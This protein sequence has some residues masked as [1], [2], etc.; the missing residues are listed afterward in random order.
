MVMPVKPAAATVSRTAMAKPPDRRWPSGAAYAGFIRFMLPILALLIVWELAVRGGWIA[1]NVFPSPSMIFARANALL[2][3]TGPEQGMLFQHIGASLYR[4][5]SAFALSVIIAIPM[6]FALGLM[7]A[8]Y[9]WVSPILS[10][11]LP[12]PAVAWT[13]ILLVAFGQGDRTI[14]TVCFL[15]AFF[16]VLYSTIQ[17]VRS[18]G[19]QPVWVVQSMGGTRRHVLLNV[20]L[21]SCMPALI[22][23][24]KLGMAHSWRTLVA[25]EMLAAL[26]AGL[27]YMIFAARSY[28]DVSTMF[29]GIALL[30]L[31]GMAIEYGVF[32]VLEQRTVRKWHGASKVGGMQ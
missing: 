14:I 29:V 2:F 23:G 4:A 32:G 19:K 13:P 12:L 8:V 5:I 11:L 22:S 27:G 6:G 24:L 1:S 21:P 17:G 3:S 26:S 15:G 25:A 30:A 7:P 20:L 9:K 10:V 18:V 28:M 16:P 31:I